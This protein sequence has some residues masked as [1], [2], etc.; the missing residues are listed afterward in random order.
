MSE[1]ER[2][3][4]A[5]QLAAEIPNDKDGLWGWT[6]KWEFVDE[7]LVEEKLKPFVEKKIVEYLGVQEQM[8]VDVV[9]EH[10]KKKGTPQELVGELEEVSL[11]YP[12]PL[13][14]LTPPRH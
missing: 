13:Q 12:S 2:Q 8:L 11:C 3:E 4:A 7:T 1:E 6:V 9:E 14:S 10:I 5:K